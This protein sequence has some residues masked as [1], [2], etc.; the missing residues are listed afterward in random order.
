MNKK[1]KKPVKPKTPLVDPKTGKPLPMTMREMA[2]AAG[3]TVP[4]IAKIRKQFPAVRDWPDRDQIRFYGA[5][6]DEARL[7]IYEEEGFSLEEDEPEDEADNKQSGFRMRL[8]KDFGEAACGMRV[9]VEK[10]PQAIAAARSEMA[11]LA[12]QGNKEEAKA[13]SAYLSLLDAYR[14]V[15]K[16]TPKALRELDDTI[17]RQ[18]YEAFV[19]GIFAA[20]EKRLMDLPAAIS[21]PGQNLPA[22]DLEEIV[23]SCVEGVR[24]TL[25]DGETWRT[26]PRDKNRGLPL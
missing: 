13:R 12:G 18:E 20:V 24:T 4:G 6:D 19:G 17:S 22:G 10:L 3:V 23:R 21:L 16:D 11:R 26:I 14:Q 9:E 15:A 8:P 2:K 5:A 1:P 7:G 25:R